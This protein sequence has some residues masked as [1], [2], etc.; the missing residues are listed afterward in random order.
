MNNPETTNRKAGLITLA[1]AVVLTL[2]T[3]ALAF[4]VGGVATLV[5]TAAKAVWGFAGCAF[6]LFICSVAALTHKTTP[7]EAI[8]QADERNQAIGNLA[9]RK[10]FTFMGV[11]MPLVALVLYVLDQVSLTAMLVIIGIEVVTF[12]TYAIYIARLQ[13]EM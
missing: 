6:A 12:V 4:N 9:A 1:I 13:R 11:F 7:Q 5:P 2:I 8:E 10:A 3:L